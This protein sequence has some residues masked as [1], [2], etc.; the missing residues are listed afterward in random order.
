MIAQ[1]GQGVDGGIRA[2]QLRGGKA[3]DA[4]ACPTV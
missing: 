3:G 2:G 4:I 1:P